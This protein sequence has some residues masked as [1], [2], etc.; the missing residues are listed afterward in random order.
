ME[1]PRV[2]R[3]RTLPTTW[4][5]VLLL[6]LAGSLMPVSRA[7]LEWHLVNSG[8][9]RPA[10]A[11]RRD[12]ALAYHAGTNTL[13]LFG[14]R[15]SNGGVLGDM[16]MYHVAMDLWR[17]VRRNQ[18]ASPA[19][20]YGAVSG[21]SEDTFFLS[22]GKG[23]SNVLFD[24]IWA[25]NIIEET[26]EELPSREKPSYYTDQQ[27]QVHRRQEVKPAYRYGAVGGIYPNTSRFYVT[28]GTSDSRHHGDMLMYATEERGW[29]QEFSEPLSYDPFSPHGR[30]QQAGAVVSRDL[31]LI[32]GG[33]L[34]GGASGGPCPS[35]DSWLY[36]VQS[37]KW[38]ALDQ[39]ASARL[40]GAIAPLPVRSGQRRAVL[41]GGQET[42]AQVLMTI[43]SP[44]DQLAVLNLDSMEWTLRQSEGDVPTKRVSVSMATATIEPYGVYM[45]GG[46]DINE[47]M[48]RNDLYLLR[49]DASTADEAPMQAQCRPTFFSLLILHGILMALACGVLLPW[50][51]FVARYAQRRDS[52]W[53]N[54]HRLFQLF[55]VVLAIGGFICGVLSVQS[56]HFSFVHA[57]VGLTVMVLALLQTLIAFIRPKPPKDVPGSRK[58]TCRILWELLHAV[59]GRCCV[60]LGLANISLGL[61]L[62][63]SSFLLWVLWFAYLGALVLALIIAEIVV[64]R[65]RPPVVTSQQGGSVT[66]IRKMAP[67]DGTLEISG[68]GGVGGGSHA[69]LV[70]HREQL[71]GQTFIV[72]DILTPQEFGKTGFDNPQRLHDG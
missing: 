25:F 3:S 55:G 42:N 7:Q 72:K 20:R 48:E 4:A 46:Y 11:P 6:L 2:F 5:A 22:T 59:L 37:R 26:W 61:F 29:Y 47:G 69:A 49:G 71:S 68:G 70:D 27:W 39:C 23:Q 34:S 12:A 41:Y 15:G 38:T 28:Q 44:A 57:I 33:C 16:W 58:S 60:G 62:I 9:A 40:D 50:G 14:G 18:S 63:I 21:L 32:Y 13:V 1:A 30:Y 64:T 54:L 36:N 65:R 45:F 51:A 19:P 56:G 10:P 17:E 8:S 52:L 67:P 24:D 43:E 53:I 31:L 35:S 66:D